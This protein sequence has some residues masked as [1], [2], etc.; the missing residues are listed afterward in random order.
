MICLFVARRR[1]FFSWLGCDGLSGGFW[2]VLNTPSDVLQ[3]GR[4]LWFQITSLFS[5]QT[6]SG[7]GLKMW[8]ITMPL[9]FCWRRACFSAST[10]LRRGLFPLIYSQHWRWLAV[11]LFV[12]FC[13]SRFVWFSTTPFCY[14]A[15][16]ICDV[17]A[18]FISNQFWRNISQNDESDILHASG[19]RLISL[20]EDTII[21]SGCTIRLYLLSFTWK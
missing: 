14:R 10:S 21:I 16:V 19:V 12:S 15:D 9:R 4:W 6:L 2:E 11:C 17:C 3:Q 13:Y 7:S 8:S 5:D 20:A 1:A 18:G